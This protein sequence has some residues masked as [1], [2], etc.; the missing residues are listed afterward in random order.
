MHPG[1]DPIEIL[2]NDL[3]IYWPVT[4]LH[5]D[6]SIEA[7][8]FRCEVDASTYDVGSMLCVKLMCLRTSTLID[9]D[10]ARI[11]NGCPRHG[12]RHSPGINSVIISSAL[13]FFCC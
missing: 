5:A 13:N 7:R 9:F 8:T 12:P 1:C 2:V 4:H 10:S 3:Q 6:D 11:G